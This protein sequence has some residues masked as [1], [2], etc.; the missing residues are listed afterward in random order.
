MP[1]KQQHGVRY[2]RQKI[3]DYISA[4]SLSLGAELPSLPGLIALFGLSRVTIWKA[5]QELKTDGIVTGSKGHPFKVGCIKTDPQPQKQPDIESL[6]NQ[7]I[8]QKTAWHRVRDS[9]VKDIVDGSFRSGTLIPPNK[10]LERRYGACFRTLQKALVTLAE[11]GTITPHKKGYALPA[12]SA[13]PWKPR[14]IC[15]ARTDNNTGVV[16]PTQHD[17]NFVR[18]LEVQCKGSGISVDI[19]ILIAKDAPDELILRDARTGQESLIEDLAS[20]KEEPILGFIMLSPW[21]PG[22][23]IH[24]IAHAIRPLKK[25]FVVFDGTGH[26]ALPQELGIAPKFIR[27][28]KPTLDSEP[29]KSVARYLLSMN[30]R[31]IAFISPTHTFIWSKKRLEGLRSVYASSGFPR[32]VNAF[33]F[34]AET[35][36]WNAAAPIDPQPLLASYER[37]KASIPPLYIPDLDIHMRKTKGILYFGKMRES[38]Y[39]LCDKACS[40]K[41]PEAFVAVNDATGTMI[42]DYLKSRSIKVPKDTLVVSFDNFFEAIQA[43]LTSYDFNI[44][45]VVQAAVGFILG[46]KP[47]LSGS[48]SGGYILTRSSSHR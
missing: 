15:I 14:I 28:F 11:E 32:G 36:T 2:S 22:N 1:G 18:G 41:I 33:T 24:R 17:E 35:E 29:G 9:I 21:E 6:P 20:L 42:L 48:E 3:L 47:F 16:L 7:Q 10:D 44:S 37:W 39:A 5:F 40:Q 38:V 25:P 8:F 43:N 45:G 31:S 34:E 27:I 30:L 26:V 12:F 4:H 13:R 46:R 23:I 19:M